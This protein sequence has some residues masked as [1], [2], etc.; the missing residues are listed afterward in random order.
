MPFIEPASDLSA[1]LTN[2]GRD[3]LANMILGELAFELADFQVGR[4]G[5]LTVN[6]VKTEA[7]DPALTALLDPVGTHRDFVTIE[8]PVGPNVAAPVC[9][10]GTGD[11]DVEYGLGELG[12]FAR[13]LQHDLQPA[14]IG[15]LF[16]FA[17]AHFPI[18]SKTASHT[19]VWRVL[20]TL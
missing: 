13:Y 8:Q 19:L 17:V 20:I 14:L 5:Y 2:E 11:V 7:I 4:G 10:L 16:L 6:P 15:T 18:V 9:R 3:A 12:V 1:R